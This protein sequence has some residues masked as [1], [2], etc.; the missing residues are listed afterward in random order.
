MPESGCIRTELDRQ[1]MASMVD[2]WK[3]PLS[4]RVVYLVALFS[5]K[6]LFRKDCRLLHAGTCFAAL[7]WRTL[8]LTKTEF[9]R[10]GMGGSDRIPS[11]I[12]VSEPGLEKAEIIC[13]SYLRSS[14]PDVSQ[15]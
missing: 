5:L 1:Q 13:E 10:R 15:N 7:L 14:Y 12:P 6:V 2:Q 11:L 3:D 4:L 9:T 8:Q